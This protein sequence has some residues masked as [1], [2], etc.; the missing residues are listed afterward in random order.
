MTKN[1]LEK[2]NLL[3]TWLTNLLEKLLGAKSDNPNLS[4]DEKQNLW[5]F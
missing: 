1:L 5:F 3:Y 2:N 4:T